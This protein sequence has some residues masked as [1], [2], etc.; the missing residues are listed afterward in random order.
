MTSE[1][2]LCAVRPPVR[3]AYSG[4][5]AMDALMRNGGPTVERRHSVVSS[6]CMEVATMRYQRLD[7]PGW[8]SG[9]RGSSKSRRDD[10]NQSMRVP[11]DRG[12]KTL[13][14]GLPSSAYS[15]VTA[16]TDT[17]VVTEE[18]EAMRN[19]CGAREAEYVPYIHQRSRSQ[20]SSTSGTSRH[21][22]NSVFVNGLV[23]SETKRRQRKLR[24]ITGQRRWNV[25]GVQEAVCGN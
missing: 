24:A 25:Y 22:A 19:I 6:R 1:H 18:I 20:P 15:S 14:H 13:C 12:R 3:P 17:T 21:S 23:E 16:P 4:V 8:A 9:S 11:G 5:D 2:G 10:D 7:A